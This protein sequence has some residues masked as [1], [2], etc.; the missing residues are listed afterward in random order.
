MKR[1]THLAAA[2]VLA[3]AALPAAAAP[4]ASIPF[5]DMGGVRDWRADGDRGIWIQATGGRWYYARFLGP[6][7]GLDFRDRV[8][9][10]TEPG[11][12]LDKFSA[13]FADGQRCSFQTF[14]PSPA[15]PR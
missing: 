14:A 3:A 10:M 4:P 5:A 2:V 11:G 9:F 1:T 6:C 8:G 7:V 12:D 15:P 13:V